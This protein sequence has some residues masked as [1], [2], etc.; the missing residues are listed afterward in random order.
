MAKWASKSGVLGTKRAY[1]GVKN[2]RL[3]TILER[4]N[5]A[6]CTQL[7]QKWTKKETHKADNC[8]KNPLLTPLFR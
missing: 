1:L 5:G 6:K 4:L 8:D 7:A 2:N 3:A